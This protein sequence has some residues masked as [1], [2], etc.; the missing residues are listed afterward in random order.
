MTQV[1]KGGGGGGGGLFCL[2]HY[3]AVRTKIGM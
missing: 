1:R 3:D 2:R